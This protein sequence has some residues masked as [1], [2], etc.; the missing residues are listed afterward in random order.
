M[1]VDIDKGQIE[2]AIN[3]LLSN[4]I[5]FTPANGKVCVRLVS[6][7][8]LFNI[9]V[10]DNGIGIEPMHHEKVFNRFY[11]VPSAEGQQGGSG[12]GLAFAKNIVELHNGTITVASESGKGTEFSISIPMR[13]TSGKALDPADNPGQDEEEALTNMP[14]AAA[15]GQSTRQTLLVVDDNDDIRTYL[16]GL[17]QDEFDVLEAENGSVGLKM[18]LEAIPDLII[19]DVMM[20]HMNGIDMCAELKNNMATSHIPIIL[21][22]AR[23]SEAY[24]LSGLKTGADDYI[25]KP[26]NPLIVQMRV[27]NTLENR[28]KLK[29]SF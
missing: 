23:A 26:F 21:L 19:S 6:D 13:Q 16:A 11:Q 29:G 2:M 9:H 17:L 8:K 5:K 18:A 10:L 28:R 3:N 24:E 12:I 7:G 27:R 1:L 15:A 22:T 20:P 14:Y 4:A 25:T